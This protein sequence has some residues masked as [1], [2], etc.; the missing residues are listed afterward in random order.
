MT[1]SCLHAWLWPVFAWL[2]P[3][4]MMAALDSRSCNSL[5]EAPTACLRR[6]KYSQAHFSYDQVP[7]QSHYL[8][9]PKQVHCISTHFEVCLKT[10]SEL[11]NNNCPG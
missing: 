10:G 2:W 4:Q 9:P 3:V 7:R 5:L 8:P 11:N 1:N 6:Q